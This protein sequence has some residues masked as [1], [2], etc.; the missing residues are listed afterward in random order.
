MPDGNQKRFR[1]LIARQTSS[2]ICRISSNI[3]IET[4]G[5]VVSNKTPHLL[6]LAL[7]SCGQKLKL[8][9]VCLQT[10]SQLI[11]MEDGLISP[12]SWTQ[13]WPK[14]LNVARSLADLRGC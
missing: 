7:P 1:Y 14:G 10:R 3:F 9:P 12:R 4:F 13:F 5:Y 8:R 11:R 6:H 2:F